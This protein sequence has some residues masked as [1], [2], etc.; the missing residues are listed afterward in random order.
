MLIGSTMPKTFQQVHVRR[1][2]AEAV[3]RD[4]AHALSFFSKEG[5]IKAKLAK[6]NDTVELLTAG[7]MEPPKRC[8]PRSQVDQTYRVRFVVRSRGVVM[9][10]SIGQIKYEPNYKGR[11]SLWILVKEGSR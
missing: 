9:F 10:T 2:Q 1:R 8:Y 3:F 11:L 7:P 4:T 6:K 5:L